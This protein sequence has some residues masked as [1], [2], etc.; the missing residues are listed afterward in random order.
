VDDIG[1]ILPGVLKMEVGR[2]EPRLLEILAPLWPR[3]A[4]KAIA[5]HSRPVAFEAGTLT[6][7]TDCPT[8]TAQLCQMAEEIRAEVNSFLGRPLVKRLRVRK[9]AGWERP[10]TTEVNQRMS[11]PVR[12]PEKL[13]LQK[14]VKF[15]PEIARIVE[16]SYAKYFS[17]KGKRVT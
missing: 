10:K 16:S 4:G 2:T 17:R 14:A 1:K 11:L 13:S 5:L 9:Q 3:V 15:E 7:A 8:W 6:L 12:L